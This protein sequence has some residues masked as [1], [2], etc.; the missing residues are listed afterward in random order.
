[1]LLEFD[2]LRASHGTRLFIGQQGD[3]K[4]MDR[5]SE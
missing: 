4:E 2:R 3:L 5:V 1:L